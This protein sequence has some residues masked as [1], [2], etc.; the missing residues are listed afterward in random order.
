MKKYGQ[1]VS[2]EDIKRI[3]QESLKIL[4]EVGVRFEHP[5][6]L[7]LF[8]EHG[9]RVEDEIVYL[10]EKMVMDAVKLCPESFEMYST[11]GSITIGNG[12]RL[13]M[14]ACGCVYVED[15]NKIRRMSNDD[16]I[17]VFKLAS[18]SPTTDYNYMDYFADTSNFTKDQKVYSNVGMLLKYSPQIACFDPDTFSV[19]HE[20]L[21]D[22]TVKSIKIIKA[23]EG[24]DERYVNSFCV[25]PLSPLCYDFAP[26]EKMFAFCAE[27]Q[28]LWFTP[29]AMPALTSPP[30]VYA[31][32]SVTNAEVLAGLT[33]A[34]LAQPGVPIIYGNTSASTNLRSILLS[35]GAPETA[36]MVYAA[37]AMAD[38]YKMPC[39][40][41]GALSDAKDADYQ[42]GAESMLLLNATYEAG[43]DLILHACGIMGSFNIFSYEK[44]L[45]D[46][47]TLMYAR[48]MVRGIDTNEE[49][50][51]FD[52][53]KKIGP[54]GSYLKGRTPKMYREE[55]VMPTF[56]NK[57][58]PNVWQ[59]E[60]AQSLKEVT[61]KVVKERIDSYQAPDIT[62]E[63]EKIVAPYIPE[64]YRDR[65]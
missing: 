63:Q 65:I 59:N 3:H 34:Q 9:A 55:F 40:T 47:D 28:P 25:N 31:T 35:I 37:V 44:F 42:A 4:S 7:A 21:F 20:E 62:K 58:E 15:H 12:S 29:C 53:I 19:D 30:S 41:G 54:R 50:S 43:T 32:I 36:L 48:R 14:P 24:T 13:N 33:L 8:K 22:A 16:T 27:N 49:K 11:K 17:N 51:C 57:Q 45:M 2:E 5:K 56:F 23:F 38:F 60:G 10:N 61:E 64:A 26:L 1:Y 18:T 6:A 46:E 39:R 52:L